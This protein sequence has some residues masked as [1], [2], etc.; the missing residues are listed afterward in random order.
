MYKRQ[1]QGHVTLGD[2]YRADSDF[3]A[4]SD[5]YTAAVLVEHT[6][7]VDWFLYYA[8]GITYEQT[9]NW[10]LAEADFMKA[11]ELKPNDPFVLNYLGYSWI[12]RGINYDK[13]RS[14]IEKAVEQRPDD[15]FLVDSLGWA[16]YLGGEYE[17]AVEVLERAVALQPGDA[18]I[19]DHLGDAY[20]Q[21][22]RTIEA[23]F[24]WRHTLDLDADDAL[25]AAVHKKLDLGLSI[26]EAPQ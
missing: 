16:H 6:E 15:G 26:A 2:L 5:A 14:M 4:A 7:T 10:P 18:T 21:V 12:D 23:R 13:A 17:K 24:K 22:G 8:R 3:Q 25:V 19:N 9:D 20:W 11:L 1:V